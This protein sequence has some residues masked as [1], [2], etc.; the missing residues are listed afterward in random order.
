MGQIGIWR[1]NTNQP[2][3]IATSSFAISVPGPTRSSLNSNTTTMSS[4]S[5]NIGPGKDYNLSQIVALGVTY[6][7]IMNATL[8]FPALVIATPLVLKVVCFL[9]DGLT[10]NHSVLTL[11]LTILL[12][13]Y[14]RQVGRMS[15]PSAKVA[16][17]TLARFRLRIPSSIFV[18]IALIMRYGIARIEE[19]LGLTK[20]LT[21]SPSFSFGLAIRL[22]IGMFLLSIAVIVQYVGPASVGEF[23]IGPRKVTSICPLPPSNSQLFLEPSAM[24][25]VSPVGESDFRMDQD[26]SIPFATFPRSLRRLYFQTKGRKCFIHSMVQCSSCPSVAATNSASYCATIPGCNC[27]RASCG[28]HNSRSCLLIVFSFGIVQ[29]SCCFLHLCY[30]HQSSCLSGRGIP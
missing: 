12:T 11:I 15:A 23:E 18:L 25:I 13:A 8:R 2:I 19:P 24:F 14:A 28:R 17:E 5:E 9:A 20:A 10:K 1:C 22:A 3:I 30:S 21:W 6:R 4:T 16:E 29:H 26:C 27:H 7:H